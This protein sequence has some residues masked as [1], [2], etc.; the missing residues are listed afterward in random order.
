M[1]RTLSLLPSISGIIIV[2]LAVPLMVAGV[3]I[4]LM[5]GGGVVATKYNL[6]GALIPVG[7]RGRRF[8]FAKT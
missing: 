1:M 3:Y 8:S 7:E 6:I 4:F 5:S 2:K